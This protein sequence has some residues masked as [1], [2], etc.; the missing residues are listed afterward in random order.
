MSTS[1]REKRERIKRRYECESAQRLSMETY[2]RCPP[3]RS[4]QGG[5]WNNKKK[6]RERY[7]GPT[8]RFIIRELQNY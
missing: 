5:E 6:E 1:Y 4:P 7:F 3:I 8:K 2:T